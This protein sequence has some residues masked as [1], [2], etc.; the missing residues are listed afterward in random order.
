MDDGKGDT[1]EMLR[2]SSLAG[3]ADL[4]GFCGTFVVDK[5]DIRPAKTSQCYESLV[6]YP[7]SGPAVHVPFAITKVPNMAIKLFHPR[8]TSSHVALEEENT[9]T[10][11]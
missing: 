4:N 7:A 8:V 9:L 11:K 1:G 3:S 10:G 2:S 5:L 6:M